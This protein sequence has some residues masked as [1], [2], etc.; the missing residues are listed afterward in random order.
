MA[1]AYPSGS[2]LTARIEMTHKLMAET[3]ESIPS[4]SPPA[5]RD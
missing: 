4:A 1:R 2:R 3:I 5:D